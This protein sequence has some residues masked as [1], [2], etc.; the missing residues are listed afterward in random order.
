M[1]SINKRTYKNIGLSEPPGLAVKIIDSS[2]DH[3]DHHQR[4]VDPE[5][6]VQPLPEPPNR[7]DPDDGRSHEH[8]VEESLCGKSSNNS[9]SGL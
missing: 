6:D 8:R 5:E 3:Q 2:S 4:G 7:G 9:V 1:R